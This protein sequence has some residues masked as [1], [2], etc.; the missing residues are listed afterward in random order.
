MLFIFYI[1]NFLINISGVAIREN[2]EN[3]NLEKYVKNFYVSTLT[4]FDYA[5]K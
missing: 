3:M 1:L 5:I 4:R 2:S